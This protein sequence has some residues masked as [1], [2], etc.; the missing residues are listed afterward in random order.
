[1]ARDRDNEHLWETPI[2]KPSIHPYKAGT[3]GR[4]Q[5]AAAVFHESS[6]EMLHI[7]IDFI[8]RLRKHRSKND[9]LYWMPIGGFKNY[10]KFCYL[11]KPSV[12][13]FVFILKIDIKFHVS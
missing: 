12:L 6:A 10:H 11:K 3:A 13:V 7:F 2:L 5:W 1:M 4:K 9:L 8:L